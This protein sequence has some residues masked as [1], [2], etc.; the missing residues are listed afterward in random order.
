[1]NL[2]VEKL[3]ATLQDIESKILLSKNIHF[4]KITLASYLN[5]ILCLD[6]VY[7]SLSISGIYRIAGIFR[8][9]IFS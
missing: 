8:G 2:F 3:P 1:M 5:R 4:A 9:V 6:N 7:I